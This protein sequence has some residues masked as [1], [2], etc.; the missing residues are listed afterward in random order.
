MG[1]GSTLER[2]REVWEASDLGALREA[3]AGRCWLSLIRGLK[4]CR[5]ILWA[6]RWR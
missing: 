5:K 2:G 1:V 4:L 6:E 3:L